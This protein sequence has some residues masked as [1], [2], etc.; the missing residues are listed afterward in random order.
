MIGGWTAYGP[1]GYDEDVIDKMLPVD[2]LGGRNEKY[3]E[4]E[5][6]VWDVTPEGFEH[7]IMRL[8]ADPDENR[9]IWEEKQRIFKGHNMV[10]R[11]KPGLL[12]WRCIRTRKTCMA[13]R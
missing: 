11:A 4:N 5:E 10:Q 6:F 2:M 8:V 3:V 7:P 1:G 12:P 13:R 9:K